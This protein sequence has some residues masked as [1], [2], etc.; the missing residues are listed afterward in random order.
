MTRNRFIQ[1]AVL[2]LATAGLAGGAWLFLL[3]PVSV[4]VAETERDVPIQVFGLGTVEARVLSRVGF[5]VA[6]TLIE[7]RADYGD[8]VA[9][10]KVLARLDSREQEARVAQARATVV[11]AESAI[12][13]AAATI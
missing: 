12:R 11:Q 7:L 10:G 9:V 5:E 3:R 1:L 8:R 2:L 4:Q 6:G 13:Q